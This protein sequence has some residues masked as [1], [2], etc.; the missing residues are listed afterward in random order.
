MGIVACCAVAFSSLMGVSG[1]TE[2][3]TSPLGKCTS[4]WRRIVFLDAFKLPSTS[5]RDESVPIKGYSFEWLSVPTLAH[6]DVSDS[7]VRLLPPPPR[8]LSTACLE[9]SPTFKVSH[10]TFQHTPIT[11]HQLKATSN[12]IFASAA[13]DLNDTS[14]TRCPP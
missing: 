5:L 8:Q 1:E 13:S 10:P 2:E 11:N 3:H 6:I 4:S 14:N 9:L 12:G 7:R